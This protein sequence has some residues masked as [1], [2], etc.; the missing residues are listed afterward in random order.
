M[1]ADKLSM[2]VII[3]C[4]VTCG[5]FVRVAFSVQG[6]VFVTHSDGLGSFKGNG[7]LGGG[8]EI[9]FLLDPTR[10]SKRP[11]LSGRIRFLT[12]SKN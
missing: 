10:L 2:K 1:V 3:A 12:C 9:L 7:L 11:L 4:F 5:M 6:V 8:S